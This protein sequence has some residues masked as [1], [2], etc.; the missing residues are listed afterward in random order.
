M[1]AEGQWKGKAGV[2]KDK[3]FLECASKS[4][5]VNPLEGKNHGKDM[6]VPKLDRIMI[7]NKLIV[8]KTQPV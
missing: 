5:F 3:N 6:S 8:P 2:F 7:L 4:N 1:D